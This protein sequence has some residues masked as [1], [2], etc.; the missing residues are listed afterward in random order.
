[1]G[2]KEMVGYQA[3]SRGGLVR[4]R[5]DGDRVHLGGQAVTVLVAE[6]VNG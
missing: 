1:L 5:M 6:L 3:S 4:V 2:K